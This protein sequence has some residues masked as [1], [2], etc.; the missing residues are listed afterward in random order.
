MKCHPGVA[1]FLEASAVMY[2]DGLRGLSQTKPL[3]FKCLFLA[4]LR[5]WFLNEFF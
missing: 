5:I 3:I 1:F 2:K 4:F